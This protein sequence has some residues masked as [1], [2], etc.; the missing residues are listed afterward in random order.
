M[1]QRP[2][3]N[4]ARQVHGKAAARRQHAV[5]G[6]YAPFIVETNI[7]I[8]AEIVALAGRGHIVVPVR[9]QLDGAAEF[10]RGERGDGRKQVRLAFLAA[11]RPAHAP[12]VH[13]HRARR[14]R[15]HM[16]HDMLHFARM[17]GR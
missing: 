5:H 13:R 2:V 4:R 1:E 11:E 9:A 6:K 16:G 7:V 3:G 14:N 17:L 8:D 10:P 12:H 15:E